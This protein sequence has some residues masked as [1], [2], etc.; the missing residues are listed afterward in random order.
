MVA[1]LVVGGLGSA[2]S[3]YQHSGSACCTTVVNSTTYTASNPNLGILL[4]ISLNPSTI[5]VGGTVNYT[6]TVYNTRP[7]VNNISSAT[8]W[9]IPRL[10]STN[11]GTSPT[12]SPIAYAIMQGHHEPG[13]ISE[14]PSINYG[15]MCT[16]V[17]G[18]AEVYSFQPSS[19]TA[20]VV[21]SCSPNPC[22]TKPVSTWRSFSQYPS[23][24]GPEPWTN[25]TTGVYTVVAEDEWGDL[26]TA[27]FTVT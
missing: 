6:A 24:G 14:A 19:D 25:F 9:A 12:D 22:F 20:S 1:V 13:N 4:I 10:I 2:Y 15:M 18:G 17:M 21:G 5:H 3:S 8:N 11:C 26:A 27:S 23:G 7:T 16:T